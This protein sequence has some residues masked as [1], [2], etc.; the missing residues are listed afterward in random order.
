M[1]DCHDGT[2]IV[3]QELLEPQHA[4]GVQ[5]V[6]GLVKQQQVGRLQQQAAQRHATALAAGKHVHRH[7][8][9]GALQRVHRLR[10]LAVQIPAVLRVDLVLQLAHLVH[11]RVEVGIG[12][13]H[14]GAHLVEA[15]HLRQDVGER[16]LNVLQD[17]LVL[18][19][20]RLLLQDAHRVAGRQARLAVGNFLQP[21]HQLQQRGLAHAVG[22][23]HAD[24]RTR[25]ERQ[26]HVVQDDLVA[27]RLARLV[28]LIN[29]FGHVICAFLS[30]V[31]EIPSLQSPSRL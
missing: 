23:H 14:L 17:G 25:V 16:Q 21:R 19:Q 18:L 4:L 31:T 20:R 27:M 6:G 10:Q 22:A 29:E 11:Q 1:R 15:L 28:H 9:V 7:V 8:G 13:A 5:V 2:G 30:G 26:R 12:V 3:V 24:L